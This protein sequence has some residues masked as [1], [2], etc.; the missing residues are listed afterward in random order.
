MRVVMTAP[1]FLLVL[2]PT[3]PLRFADVNASLADANTQDVHPTPPYELRTEIV[4]PSPAFRLRTQIER[5]L[6]T[7]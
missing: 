1:V 6:S 2:F 4:T 3:P 7:G 5:R